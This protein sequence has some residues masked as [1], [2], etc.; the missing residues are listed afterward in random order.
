MIL[1]HTGVML[2]FHIQRA[3]SVTNL[4]H[5]RT[6]AARARSGGFCF[7]LLRVALSQSQ[8]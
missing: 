2:I 5:E 1:L 7:R 3:V 4:A 6:C 8:K